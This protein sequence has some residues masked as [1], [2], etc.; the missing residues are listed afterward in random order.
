MD[1]EYPIMQLRDAQTNEPVSVV[2]WHIRAFSEVKAGGRTVTRIDYAN[3]DTFD[4]SEGIATVLQR[5]KACAGV[6]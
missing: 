1:D 3:G 4:S 6:E 2:V 5:F